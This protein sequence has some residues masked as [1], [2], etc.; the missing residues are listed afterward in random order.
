M[1]F[2][3]QAAL[4]WLATSGRSWAQKGENNGRIDG[5]SSFW[6]LHIPSAENHSAGIPH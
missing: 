1:D 2:A 5:R 4:L 6:P 3:A